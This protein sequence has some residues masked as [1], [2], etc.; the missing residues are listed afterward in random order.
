MKAL[1]NPLFFI[2][3]LFIAGIVTAKLIIISL[4]VSAATTTLFFLLTLYSYFKTDT[5]LLQKS[6][7]TIAAG[8]LSFCLGVFIYNIHHTPNHKLHYSNFLT[9][10]APVIKGVISERL[11]PN[12]SYEKYFFKIKTVNRQQ[13][14]GKI[15]VSI[16]KSKPLNIGDRVLITEAPY[17]IQKPLNPYQFDYAAYMA[18]QNVFHQLRLKNNYIITGQIKD[19]NYYIDNFRK[20]LADSFIPHSFTRQTNGIIQALLLGQRQDMDLNITQNYADAGVIHIL[21]ISGLHIGILFYILNFLTVPLKR[22]GKKG[23]LTQLILILSTLC[24]FAVLSGLSPSVM[25]AVVMFSFVSIGFFINRKA[26]ILNS[27]IISML[28]LLVVN[29]KQLFDIGFQLSYVAVTG[30]VVLQPVYKKLR[31][32][33]YQAVNY[34]IDTSAITIAAQIAV[35]PLTLYY[36]NQFPIL[37]LPANIVV[38]PFTTAILIL[39]LIT[40]F[41]NFI[42]IGTAIFVGKILNFLIESMN[43]FIAFITSLESFTVKNITFNLMLCFLLY[44]LLIAL[45]LWL[46]KQTYKRTVVVMFG[47]LIFQLV[48]T[49]TK[50]QSDFTPEFIIF[51][52]YNNSVIAFK[53]SKN[54]TI[55]GND[56]LANKSREVIAYQRKNFHPQTSIKPLVNLFWFE[57]NKILLIDKSGLYNAHATP[58]LLLITQSPKINLERALKELKPK[59]VV[60]DGTNYKNRIAL[61]KAT[62]KK[63]N[64]PFHATAEKGYYSIK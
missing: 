37:F 63:H 39:G 52:N 21:S 26:P 29:P 56:S 30:I 1:K 17:L 9:K 62:C 3:V 42:H 19:F 33:K 53:D 35:L 44:A 51:N 12:D 61:W 13:A 43:R 8:L 7:F 60:A 48:Y 22:F 36:F 50:A 34:L 14:T 24:L 2:V 46:Y 6:H 54:L 27:I 49:G 4:I 11:K 23:R 41:L 20:I 58:D 64:I 45:L 25:R 5:N 18:N 32:S 31:V 15:L 10:D 40:L 55:T 59:Q 57:G 28:L 38:I 16:P 47:I